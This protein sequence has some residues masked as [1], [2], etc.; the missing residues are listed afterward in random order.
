MSSDGHGEL[1]VEAVQGVKSGVPTLLSYGTL[2][3]VL[4]PVFVIVKVP[5]AVLAE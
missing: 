4:S 1:K 5:A 3:L 2:T